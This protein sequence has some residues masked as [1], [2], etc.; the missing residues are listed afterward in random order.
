[1][2]E[3]S[4]LMSNRVSSSLA[5][6]KNQ[7]ATRN[8]VCIYQKCCLYYTNKMKAKALSHLNLSIKKNY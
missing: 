3:S 2:C 6:N 8:R 5:R 4:S 1:M 7:F